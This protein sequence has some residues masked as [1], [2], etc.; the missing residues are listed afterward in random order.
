VP[1]AVAAKRATLTPNCQGLAV[2]VVAEQQRG[3]GQ[4]AHHGG[5]QSGEDRAHGAR[6]HVLHEQ[7]ADQYHQYERRQHQGRGGRGRAEDG[8]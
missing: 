2:G 4:Q 5:P 1:K 3:G 7:A 6:V 8:H